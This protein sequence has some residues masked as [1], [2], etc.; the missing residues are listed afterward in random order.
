MTPHDL[1]K[2]FLRKARDDLT[3]LRRLASDPAVADEVGVVVEG[4]YH[5]ITEFDPD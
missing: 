2:V 4:T 3:A 5:G 1:A